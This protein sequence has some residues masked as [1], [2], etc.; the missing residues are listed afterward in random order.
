MVLTLHFKFRHG[1]GTSCPALKPRDFQVKK[2]AD[3]AILLQNTPTYL[4]A[5]PTNKMTPTSVKYS[6]LKQQGSPTHL[7]AEGIL[8]SIMKH[9]KHS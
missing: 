2:L 1:T 5:D 4:T 9:C 3:V 8:T 6:L 7:F